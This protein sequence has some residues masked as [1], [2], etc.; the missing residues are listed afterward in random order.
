MQT[1]GEFHELKSNML[2]KEENIIGNI[3]EDNPDKKTNKIIRWFMFNEVSTSPLRPSSS[4]PND[5]HIVE[6]KKHQ[7]DTLYSLT[8]IDQNTHTGKKK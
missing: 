7:D 1:L 2:E 4:L 6:G 5:Q 3:N 8:K